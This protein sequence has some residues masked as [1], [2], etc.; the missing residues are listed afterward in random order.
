LALKLPADESFL[1]TSE[2]L[3]YLNLNLRTVYRLIKAGSLPAVRV[4]RQWRFRK[5]DL[6][7]WLES[8]RRSGVPAP[9]RASSPRRRILL[10][11]D[12]PSIR[13]LLTKMLETVYDVEAAAD[14]RSALDRLRTPGVR[15]DLLISDLHMPDMDGL[16]LIREVRRLSAGLPAI[17]ITGYSSESSAIDAVNVGVA[18][19]LTKPFNAPQV[20]AMAAR[21]LGVPAA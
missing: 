3:E 21:A 12:E 6:D 18:G 7:A 5:R 2:V 15:V 16:T 4:G 19:Y 20:L 13:T 17:I 10:V 14:G 8:Q 11:D 9:D 1:T